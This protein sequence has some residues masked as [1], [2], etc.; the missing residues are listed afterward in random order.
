MPDRDCP[1]CA[2]NMTAG[3][4]GPIELDFCFKCSGI[5]FDCDELQRVVTAGPVVLRRVGERLP[6][7]AADSRAQSVPRC[8]LC[9][10][11]L[12][13]VEYASMP[14]V[15]M[16]ACQFCEGFW[17]RQGALQRL[18][19]ALE[20][21]ATWDQMRLGIDSRT[22]SPS[23][24]SART[25]ARPDAAEPA[26]SPAP[27]PARA[28]AASHRAEMCPHCGEAN[29]ENAAVCWACGKA[30]QGPVVGACP[31]CEAH[32]RRLECGGVTLNACE[33]CGGVCITPNRLNSLLLQE[34]SQR[35]RL[36]K[37]VGRFKPERIKRVHANPNC[38]IC[39]AVRLIR[40]PLGMLTQQTAHTCPQCFQLFLEHGVLEDI[41]LGQAG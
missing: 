11:P 2:E 9:R 8:P 5:W 14:G 25:A 12:T 18:T 31:R 27:A 33:G 22:L 16:D 3:R 39:K 4:L 28:P 40:A 29:S 32:I 26:V 38:P 7:S 24:G 41:L 10:I 17:V 20:G 36:V 6:A 1:Q 37:Q 23:A 21:A 35:A 15:R 19:A 13:S 30:L 34:R